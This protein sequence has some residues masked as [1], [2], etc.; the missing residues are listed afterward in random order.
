MSIGHTVLNDSADVSNRSALDSQSVDGHVVPR[1]KKSLVEMMPRS[2]HFRPD[3]SESERVIFNPSSTQITVGDIVR[4]SFADHTKEGIVIEKVNSYMVKVDF[5]EYL[6]DVL[7][8]HCAVIIRGDEFEVG[9]K[10]E[11]K[12][13]T[14]SLFFVGKVIKIHE[15]K[16]MDVLMDGDDP[17]DIEFRI[18]KENTRKLMSRRSVVVNR[19]KRAFMLVVAANFFSRISIRKKADESLKVIQEEQKMEMDVEVD[20]SP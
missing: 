14:S 3:Y 4:V 7:L 8:E 16:S 18:P 6:K 17:D 19:W 10:V 20:A 11:A 15:D 9:D 2:Y 1:R 13:I 12:P 5:G